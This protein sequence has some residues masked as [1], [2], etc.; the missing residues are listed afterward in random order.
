MKMVMAFSSAD[1]C[2][3]TPAGE[4]VDVNGCSQSQLDDDNDGVTQLIVVPIR[5][6]EKV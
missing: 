5:L 2:P 6:R 1:S 3:S 4:S